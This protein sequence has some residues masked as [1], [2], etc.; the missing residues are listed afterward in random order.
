MNSQNSLTMPAQYWY[1]KPGAVNHWFYGVFEGG[2]AKGVAYSGALTAMK[3]RNCWFRSVAG[4]SAGAI[5]AALIAAGL[6]PQ[7]MSVET[8]EALKSIKT[9]VLAGLHRLQNRHTTGYF[10]SAKLHDWLN[11]LLTTQVQKNGVKPS[12]KVTFEE[13]YNATGIEL[14]VVAAD[15][16]IRSQIPFSYL[17][18]PNCAVADAVVASS[19][20]PF[21]FGSCLLQSDDNEIKNRST[22]HTVV[23]G[24]VWSN[25]P[26]YIYEDKVFRR[27]YNRE[28]EEIETQR[29]LGFLLKHEHERPPR[30]KDVK[31]VESNAV[32]VLRAKEWSV[33][34]NTEV[35][36]SSGLG[37]KIGTLL[38]YPFSLLGRVVEKNSGIERGRWQEPRS[39]LV[40][41]LVNSVNGLLGG[42]HPILFGLLAFVVVVIGAW[43]VIGGIGT[44]ELAALWVT[45]WT[46][47]LSYVVRTITVGL[48]LLAIAIAILVVFASLLGVLANFFLL[49]ASRRVL[50]G[51]VTTYIA[52]PGAP[53]W[54][55][56]KQNIIAL[57]IPP[58]IKTLSFNL[59]SEEKQKLIESAQLATLAK[60]DE[61]LF[62]ESRIA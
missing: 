39:P 11:K 60:L 12:K 22:H 29:V 16:S 59:K 27:E 36:E 15:I 62:E 19:S 10:P 4:A 38:L 37:S 32:E 7:E 58:T 55:A 21:A 1:G 25:F 61:I 14:N 43:Q 35:D 5:T 49:R 8:D 54:M 51:L 13:L 40:R 46:A 3:K 50:Y 53:E 56:N 33:E 41:Y 48:S 6:S 34:R 47:P 57:P 42:I 23:D 9:G 26:M 31:F 18:T 24:G 17:D 28:P 30:G 2:G 45:D 44:D 52:G 20:I